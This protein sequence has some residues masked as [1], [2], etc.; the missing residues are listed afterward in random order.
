MAMKP[1]GMGI[2]VLFFKRFLALGG[3]RAVLWPGMVLAW[4]LMAGGSPLMAQTSPA[5]YPGVAEDF[6]LPPPPQPPPPLPE[7]PP[8]PP[9]GTPPFVDHQSLTPGAGVDNVWLEITKGSEKAVFGQV[10]PAWM[11]DANTGTLEVG[12][13]GLKVSIQ[14]HYAI[15]R[16]TRQQ[17]RDT[18][19]FVGADLKTNLL[20][21]YLL[22]NPSVTH[23]F[24]PAFSAGMGV[25]AGF[26]GVEGTAVFASD[27]KASAAGQ[28]QP[29]SMQGAALGPNAYAMY[30]TGS[31]LFRL[32]VST[33]SVSS[34]SASAQLTEDTLSAG[35]LWVFE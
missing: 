19:A 4:V 20:V 35:W 28:G 9:P 10:V 16:L 26:L 30:Q 31:W 7:T 13:S 25:N 3:V 8:P 29:F 14:V 21:Y 24:T 15:F 11:T 34:G 23:S 5:R 22:L 17:V 33:A 1:D 6:Y 32:G 2:G 18:G 12:D 27:T